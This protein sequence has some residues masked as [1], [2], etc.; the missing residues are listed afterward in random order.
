MPTLQKNIAQKSNLVRPISIAHFD[1]AHPAEVWTCQQ[2]PEY[3]FRKDILDK[4]MKQGKHSFFVY[5]KYCDED[6]LFK[7]VKAKNS[8][9]VMDWTLTWLDK[10]RGAS[11]DT[12]VNKLKK[13]KQQLEKFK[14]G[15]TTCTHCNEVV[16]NDNSEHWIH[17][18]LEAPYKGTC[19]NN[20]MMRPHIKCWMCKEKLFFKPERKEKSL[21][22]PPSISD[23]WF[24]Q[25]DLT[26]HFKNVFDTTTCI[27][28]KQTSSWSHHLGKCQRLGEMR[29]TRRMDL[30]NKIPEGRK[31]WEIEYHILYCNSEFTEQ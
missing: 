15:T 16:Q 14:K 6:I 25:D 19:I 31:V 26:K 2:C 9:F 4:H 1:P 23:K 17:L 12:C 21:S 30:L 22:V 24:H 20:L 13:E 3:F 28:D 18:D 5:C 29:R 7:S 8:H 11:K 27:R 10:L